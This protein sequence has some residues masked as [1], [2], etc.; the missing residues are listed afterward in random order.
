MGEDKKKLTILI[1]EDDDA[2]AQLIKTNI[3]RTG[4][5]A[6]C[7]RARNGQEVLDIIAD[8]HPSEKILDDSKLIMM[9]DIRMPKVDGIQVLKYFKSNNKLKGIPIIMMTTSNRPLEVAECYK[10]GC[11]LYLKKQVDYKKFVISIQHLINFIEICE[12]PT[13]WEMINE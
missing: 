12:L 5:D 13:Y 8:K 7:M 4:I 10:N 9:L 2:A 6:I 1:A 3:K 11:C